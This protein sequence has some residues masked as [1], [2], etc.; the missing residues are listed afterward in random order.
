MFKQDLT[1]F[2][3]HNV[4][5]ALVEDVREGDLTAQ[6][7]APT[8]QATARLITRQHAVLCG[9]AWFD[10]C[11]QAMDPHCE[12]QW[13]V[14]EGNAIT[15]NQLLCE[16]K[17]NAR[18]LLTAE[19]S[20]LN[21]LQTLSG[22]ATITR[23]YVE[24]VAGINVKIMDTRK[25]LPSLRMAQ[26]YAV[27]VGGGHNQRIGLFDGILIKENHIAAAGGIAAVLAKAFELATPSVSVQIEV[28]TLDEL[29]Q[30]LSAGAK[31]IL[32]DNF[33]LD[34]LRSAVIL[35]GGHAELEASG[36]I[37]LE[38]LRDIALTGVDRISI[39]TLTKDLA[40]VDFSLRIVW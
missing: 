30:A 9:K 11:F 40:S 18:A 14:Q 34:G 16:I 21:F 6:L 20:A 8:L 4:A 19:R 39:G 13:H 25:T 35:T 12:I 7:L 31:L 10:T 32:L 38:T 27:Q 36:G 24:Q 28:E 17:G 22:T 26:K 5:A 37:T 29:Q 15:P 2:I 3:Q 1:T 23:R 33:D